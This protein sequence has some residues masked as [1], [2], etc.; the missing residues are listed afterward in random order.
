MFLTAEDVVSAIAINVRSNFSTSE[1]KKIYKDLPQQNIQKPYA[2]IHQIQG[3]HQNELKNRATWNYLLDVRV[4]PE[5]TQTNI[6]TWARGI[7]LKLL[8]ALNVITISGMAVKGKSI[9]WKV[10]DGVLHFIVSYSFRVIDIREDI[11]DMQ[12]LAYGE[13]IKQ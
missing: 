9:E 13:R 5:N 12:T 8:K 2:F 4:H 11:P 6:Q 7:A 3:S 10:E 1:I